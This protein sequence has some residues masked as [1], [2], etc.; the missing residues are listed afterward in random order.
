MSGFPEQV[1]R[2]LGIVGGSMCNKIGKSYNL[3]IKVAQKAADEKSSDIRYTALEF[4]IN[5]RRELHRCP[6]LTSSERRHDKAGY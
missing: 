5:P 3:E 6:K 4:G 2:W 1:P